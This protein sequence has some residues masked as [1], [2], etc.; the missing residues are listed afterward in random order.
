MINPN[1]KDKVVLITGANHGIGA[2]TAKAFARQGAKVFITYFRGETAVSPQEMAQAKEHNTGGPA[3]Y[4]AN[5][6]QP[7]VPFFRMG[8]SCY[9]LKIIWVMRKE[10]IASALA[11][12]KFHWLSS[13]RDAS[14]DLSMTTKLELSF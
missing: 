5:Q 11:K 14:E 2:A 9:S 3:L 8:Q 10:P 6:Q 13:G 1:L 12:T 4:A 7:N